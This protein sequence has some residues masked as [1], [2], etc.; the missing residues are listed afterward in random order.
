MSDRW[1]VVRQRL[2]YE[3]VTPLVASSYG[4]EVLKRL[5]EAQP[6]VRTA[7]NLVSIVVV[8]PVVLSEADGADVKAATLIER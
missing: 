2:A 8:L 1:V 6:A 4:L 3:R 7:S 5:R